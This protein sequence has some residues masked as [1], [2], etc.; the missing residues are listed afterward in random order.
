MFTCIRMGIN[1]I[2]S[3][4]CA[5]F[6]ITYVFLLKKEAKLTMKFIPSTVN[7]KKKRAQTDFFKDYA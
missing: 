5:D 1:V 3:F 4:V 2:L 7:H 6:S